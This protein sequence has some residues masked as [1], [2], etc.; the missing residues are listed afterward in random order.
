M[1]YGVSFGDSF[2]MLH[3]RLDKGESIIAGSGAMAYM[4]TGIRVEPF[5]KGGLFSSVSRKLFGKESAFLNRYRALVD[6]SE[7][8][9]V[10][11]TSLGSVSEITLSPDS[12]PI[13]VRPGGFLAAWEDSEGN[14]EIEGSVGGFKT[15]FG[16]EGFE[17]LQ[18]KGIGLVFISGFG[19]IYRKDLKG[20]EL[21]VDTGHVLAYTENLDF[22]LKTVG[23][24]KS[25]LLSGE[26]LVCRFR[27]VGS[28]WIQSRSYSE[29]FEF[30]K[31]TLFP[32]KK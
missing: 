18:I 21:I 9:I 3:F 26:G 7:L 10:S 30:L 27:G 5:L 12:Y 22:E 8:G 31:K 4:D 24:I 11:N 25:T 2:S 16:M 29:F 14:V 20:N 32:D 6:S 19:G 15:Y 1:E 13:K 23:G 17:F 28:V